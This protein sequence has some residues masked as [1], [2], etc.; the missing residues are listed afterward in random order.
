MELEKIIAMMKKRID[1]L[2]GENQNLKSD[3]DRQR[4][5]VRDEGYHRTDGLDVEF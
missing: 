3:L 5:E 1:A 4:I 2:Q